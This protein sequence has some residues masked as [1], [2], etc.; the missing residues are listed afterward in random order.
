MCGFRCVVLGANIFYQIVRRFVD[1][2]DRIVYFV[3]HYQPRKPD[4][5]MNYHEKCVGYPN[6]YVPHQP[7]VRVRT[8]YLDRAIKFFRTAFL[9]FVHVF[10]DNALVFG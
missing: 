1:L 5:M 3:F 7:S 2:I 10:V 4:H 8:E 9:A 6:K